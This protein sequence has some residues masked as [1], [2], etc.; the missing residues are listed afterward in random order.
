MILYIDMTELGQVSYAI[1]ADRKV[2]KKIFKVAPHESHKALA[3]L[4]E[5]LKLKK[6]KLSDIKKVVVNKG[7]GAFTG[8]RVSAAHSLALGLGLKIPVKFVTKEK[9]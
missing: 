2:F 7:P 9:F 4:E 3:K 1:K 6:I 5:F 8:L